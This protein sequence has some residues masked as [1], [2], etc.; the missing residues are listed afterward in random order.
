MQDGATMLVLAS[1]TLMLP[2]YRR[3]PEAEWV[4]Y[5]K[6]MSDLTMLGREGSERRVKAAIEKICADID[7]VCDSCRA[8]YRKPQ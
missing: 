8:A 5:A 1:N 3:K 7:T 6:S 4:A 2:A